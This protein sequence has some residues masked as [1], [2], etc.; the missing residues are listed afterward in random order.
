MKL[1]EIPRNSK[2]PPAAPSGPGAKRISPRTP[3][4]IRLWISLVPYWA[5]R[6][7]RATGSR[8]PTG[9]R[10]RFKNYL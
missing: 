7:N 4:A 5:L 6:G 3:W 9:Y 2:E 1:S 8:N 10:T